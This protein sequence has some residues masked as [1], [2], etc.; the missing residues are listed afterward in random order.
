MTKTPQLVA[1]SGAPLAQ[2]SLEV[3]GNCRFAVPVPQ[4]MRKISCRGTPPT[5]VVLGGQQTPMGLQLQI[6]CYWPQLDTAT[7]ACAL[8]KGRKNGVDLAR[9]QTEGEG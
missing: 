5:P 1:A 3:C 2:A 7:P 9:A 4:D 8:W 6:E